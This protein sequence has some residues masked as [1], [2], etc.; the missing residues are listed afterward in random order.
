MRK[1][2]LCVLLL[3][4][5]FAPG[6]IA[7]GTT[8]EESMAERRP[9]RDRLAG[10]QWLRVSWR[11]GQPAFAAGITRF[12][13]RAT[14]RAHRQIGTPRSKSGA[15]VHFFQPNQ[16]MPASPVPLH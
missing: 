11:K 5:S 12:L 6:Q 14:A 4:V 3:I 10:Q 1:I 8:P 9:T 13:G 2:C 15:R 7:S 16:I